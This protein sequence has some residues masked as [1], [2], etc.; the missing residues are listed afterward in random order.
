M[1]HSY[2]IQVHGYVTQT[3]NTD[4]DPFVLVHGVS[5]STELMGKNNKDK[6]KLHTLEKYHIY[7]EQQS[8]IYLETTLAVKARV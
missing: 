1:Y 7:R 6:D 3:S 5:A 4:D 8:L 2:A